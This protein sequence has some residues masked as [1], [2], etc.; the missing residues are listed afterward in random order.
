MRTTI[1]LSP[2]RADSNSPPPPPPPGGDG[3]NAAAG[4]SNPEPSE[5][6]VS[7]ATVARVQ[8]AGSGRGKK[9]KKTS[10]QEAIEQARMIL[11]AED[12]RELERLKTVCHDKGIVFKDGMYPLILACPRSHRPLF[13]R[14]LTYFFKYAFAVDS[15]DAITSMFGP[16]PAP[17]KCQHFLNMREEDIVAVA[18]TGQASAIAT[19]CKNRGFPATGAVQALLA[20]ESLS[21]GGQLDQELLDAVAAMCRG[22]GVPSAAAVNA[23]LGLPAFKTGDALDKTLLKTVAT[24]HTGKGIPTEDAVKECLSS[25]TPRATDEQA[26]SA[27]PSSAAAGAATPGPSSLGVGAAQGATSRRAQ[28]RKA[29]AAARSKESAREVLMHPD[30]ATHEAMQALE[31]ICR[32][33]HIHIGA[34]LYDLINACPHNVQVPFIQKCT[35][36]FTLAK[37]IKNT[38]SL[39]NMFERDSIRQR[40]LFSVMSDANIARVAQYGH[41]QAVAAMSKNKGFPS[42][43]AVR[44]LL[45]HPSLTASGQLDMELLKSI[46]IMYARKG[47]PSAEAVTELLAMNAFKIEG[48]FNLKLFQTI[49]TMYAGKRFPTEG[50]VAAFLALDCLKTSEGTLDW[51]KLNGLAIMSRERGLPHKDAITKL[52]TMSC[53]QTGGRFSATLFGSIATICDRKGLPTPEQVT[54]FLTLK[55]LQ[56]NDN[57]DPTLLACVSSINRGRGLP[58]QE[59]VESLLSIPDLEVSRGRGY[60]LLR[61]I[62]SMCGCRGFPPTRDVQ[63]L[64]AVPGMKIGDRVDESVLKSISHMQHYRGLPQAETVR[65]L[66]SLLSSPSG[67]APS[68][69]LLKSISSLYGRLGVPAIT[70]ARSLLSLPGLMVAG[71]LDARLLRQVA[72]INAGKGFPDQRIIEQA[73]AGF[74]QGTQQSTVSG[75]TTAEAP[76]PSSSERSRTPPL[77]GSPRSFLAKRPRKE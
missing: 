25:G 60:P 67:G 28:K 9:R 56:K 29:L 14:K 73:R 10:S 51:H 36:Y 32:E 70:E 53:F 66:L 72:K 11:Q 27:T 49:T 35:L 50:D 38:S 45:T 16:E 57:I 37:G 12:N 68:L 48:A 5:F 62:S 69:D 8:A 30:A 61:S 77:V 31:K 4:P 63:A 17:P 52:L 34:S 74:V 39:I 42:A 20:C 55:A 1:R 19:M 47:I 40:T 71:R 21:P 58:T 22:K 24:A 64:L 54:E 15:T 65:E 41:V 2:G 46:S 18:R 6:D 7:R 59:Q 76:G 75:G 3:D 33:R 23:L 43:G 13:I 44:K 26:A